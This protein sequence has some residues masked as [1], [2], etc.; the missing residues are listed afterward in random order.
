MSRC[1]QYHLDNTLLSYTLDICLQG[2]AVGRCQGIVSGTGMRPTA[3]NAALD[4]SKPTRVFHDG[5]RR[6]LGLTRKSDLISAD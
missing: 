1:K 6:L 4:A 5:Y 3:A 2:F